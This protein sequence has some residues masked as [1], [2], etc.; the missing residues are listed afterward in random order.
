MPHQIES[1]AWAG[2]TPWHGLGTQVDP[3]LGVDQMLVAAGLDWRV[4][5]ERLYV[6][7]DGR[8]VPVPG[9]HALTR[10]SDGSVLSVVGST[11]RPVQNHEALE[12]FRAFVEAGD[13]RLETAGSLGGGKRIWALAALREEFELAGGDAVSGYLLFTNPHGLNAALVVQFTPIRVVCANTIAMALNGP[14]AGVYRHAH[15]SDFDAE[16][17]KAALG[18]A[19]HQLG[20]FRETAAFLASRRY[21]DDTVRRF[22]VDVFEPLRAANDE[23]ADLVKR[24]RVKRAIDALASQPGGD[25][26]AA[27]GTWWGALNAVT[28]LADHRLGRGADTRLSSAWYGEARQFKLR[29]LS[30]AV[31]YAKAA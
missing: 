26:K 2:E 16:R 3:D 21:T 28:W 31:D 8:D 24:P 6:R 30:Q 20:E 12:F 22:L 27:A 19:K 9:H 4:A 1:I 23:T 14:S 13:M 10:S 17:A 18:L 11:Y 5:K 29:A 25:L 7:R 15:F